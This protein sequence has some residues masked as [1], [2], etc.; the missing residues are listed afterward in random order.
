MVSAFASNVFVLSSN[1]CRW[2][3]LSYQWIVFHLTVGERERE[4]VNAQK[5]TWHHITK[6]YWVFLYCHTFHIELAKSYNKQAGLTIWPIKLQHQRTKTGGLPWSPL[7]NRFLLVN[8]WR[9]QRG[10]IRCG[11]WNWKR[12]PLAGPLARHLPKAA[13]C[14]HLA[15]IWPKRP[16]AVTCGHLPSAA[17]CGHL[18]PL[19][20]CGHLRVTFGHLPSAVTCGHWAG[21][22]GHLLQRPLAA[23]RVSSGCKWLQVTAN[24]EIHC[25]LTT[26]HL[27]DGLWSL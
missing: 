25:P 9:S 23:S 27:A 11:I 5:Y 1:S 17:T 8:S 18:R 15:A 22:V 14:G 10:C 4:G 24:N 6:L 12:R 3:L 26:C 21:L 7:S 19:A 16:L 2:T 13:T 20:L